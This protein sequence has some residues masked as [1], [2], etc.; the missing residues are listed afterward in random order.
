MRE[1]FLFDIINSAVIEDKKLKGNHL[2]YLRNL[3][4]STIL[5]FKKRKVKKV[6]AFKEEEAGKVQK[7]DAKMNLPGVG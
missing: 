4:R 7:Q 1:S 6:N 3:S 5:R 2:Q